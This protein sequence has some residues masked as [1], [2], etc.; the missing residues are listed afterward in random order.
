MSLPSAR[1]LRQH[2]C[3]FLLGAPARPHAG[4]QSERQTDGEERERCSR[5]AAC[6]LFVYMNVTHIIIHLVP[7]WWLFG[8]RVACLTTA[9]ALHCTSK[10]LDSMGERSDQIVLFCI[11]GCI[12]RIADFLSSQYVCV[13]PCL[14]L[15]KFFHTLCATKKLWADLLC[16]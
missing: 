16:V 9:D 5:Q 15:S 14:F 7:R 1:C 13:E 8:Q 11:S 3:R 6:I 10:T 4:A 2:S 12:C